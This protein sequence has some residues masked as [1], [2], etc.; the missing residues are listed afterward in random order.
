MTLPSGWIKD[1]R[2]GAT[3]A[4]RVAP[5][6]SRTALLGFIGEGAGAALKIALCAP[7]IEGKAN[8][9]LVAFLAEVL[10]V[11]RSRV[12]V[13]AGSQSRN[14]VIRARG[15]SGAQLAATFAQLLQ[16]AVN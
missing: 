13:M 7:P 12:E 11:P 16:S 10:N 4:A 8:A 15:I 2:E 5:R 9:A 1:T 14:K 3:F 6:A